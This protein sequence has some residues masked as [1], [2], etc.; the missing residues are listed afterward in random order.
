M[1]NLKNCLVP[2]RSLSSK[3]S[4]IESFATIL[5]IQSRR[6]KLENFENSRR[7]KMQNCRNS[8]E[9]KASRNYVLSKEGEPEGRV[10]G[11]NSR[12]GTCF[13]VYIYICVHAHVR[14]CVH[15]WDRGKLLRILHDGDTLFR[16]L[17]CQTARELAAFQRAFPLAGTRRNQ[18]ATICARPAS[19]ISQIKKDLNVSF[20]LQRVPSQPDG[21]VILFLHH[22]LFKKKKKTHL[23]SHKLFFFSS[24]N[25]AR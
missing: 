17:F 4:T 14:V 1:E 24:K 7:C 9:L 23:L 15:A 6:E 22:S 25:H 10:S 20:A 2:K 21:L 16:F 13:V 18:R 3:F 5:P 12:K 8:K 11:R 19:F